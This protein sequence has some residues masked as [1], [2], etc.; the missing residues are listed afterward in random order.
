M[1]PICRKIATISV[2]PHRCGIGMENWD[3]NTTG[4]PAILSCRTDHQ[5]SLIGSHP[6]AQPSPPSIGHRSPS[7]PP[8]RPDEGV[9]LM[10]EW[11]APKKKK[12]M[13]MYRYQVWAG[14]PYQMDEC[15][16]KAILPPWFS[17]K[18]PSSLGFLDF[19]GWAM[20]LTE[21]QQKQ[22]I[23]SMT[24]RVLT[25]SPKMVLLHCLVE[26]APRE[27]RAPAKTRSWT[28]KMAGWE[29][30]GPCCCFGLGFL[31]KHPPSKENPVDLPNPAACLPASHTHSLP[32]YHPFLK[33]SRLERMLVAWR[34]PAF[35]TRDRGSATEG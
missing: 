29:E 31:R 4:Q 13:M 32:G 30:F 1:R 10:E 23:S 6:A 14:A 25:I 5:T 11:R 24:Q 18:V 8:R 7:W 26:E 33:R 9:C 20:G 3:E 28:D 2:S 27:A 19:A 22:S 17:D 21:Q 35:P 16:T 34:L 15:G 12:H